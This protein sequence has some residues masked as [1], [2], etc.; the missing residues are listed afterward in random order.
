MII[1]HSL[2]PFAFIVSSTIA[3]SAGGAVVEKID[4]MQS[5]NGTWRFDV[6]VSH[7]DEGWDHYADAWE[8]LAPDGTLLARRVLAHPH[9][10]EQ[11]FTRSKSGIKIPDDLDHVMVRARDSVH[12][13]E[14]AAVRYDLK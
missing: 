9:V 4:A 7:G 6:T 3:A 13:Y 10:D 1:R 11:P 2:L 8:V 5:G 12:G 14:G